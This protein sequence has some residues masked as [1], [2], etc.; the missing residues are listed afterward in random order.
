[1]PTRTCTICKSAENPLGRL[2]FK[3]FLDGLVYCENCLPGHT[4]VLDPVS[5]VAASSPLPG[6]SAGS[7]VVIPCPDCFGQ[8]RESRNPTH[9]NLKPCKACVGYGQ[10]RVPENFLNIYLPKTNK[11]EGPQVLTES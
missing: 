2:R 3:K 6:T 7:F 10:V 8:G 5:P 4:E 11:P 9:S 1:M